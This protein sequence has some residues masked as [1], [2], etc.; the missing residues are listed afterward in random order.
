MQSFVEL[1]LTKTGGIRQIFAEG[2]PK[3]CFGHHLVPTC[4]FF[5]KSQIFSSI[6]L[7]PTKF[8]PKM[9]I[10]STENLGPTYFFSI[11]GNFFYGKFGTHPYSYPNES[12]HGIVVALFCIKTCL[13]TLVSL[14]CFAFNC[15]NVFTLDSFYDFQN[16]DIKN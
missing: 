1:F 7:G 6:F 10:F 3:I 13:K 5:P 14:F 16:S 2:M 15:L 9:Q 4:K 8:F 12:Q 11:N